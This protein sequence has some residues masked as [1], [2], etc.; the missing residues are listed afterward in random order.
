M[1]SISNDKNENQYTII[2]NSMRYNK[3]QMSFKIEGLE[4]KSK[5]FIYNRNLIQ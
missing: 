4:L 3:I 2:L 5:R 1:K